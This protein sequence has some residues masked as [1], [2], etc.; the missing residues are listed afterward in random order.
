M[1]PLGICSPAFYLPCIWAML[2]T[3]AFYASRIWISF[4]LFW[5]KECS[6]ISMCRVLGFP[7]KPSAVQVLGTSEPLCHCDVTILESQIH[8]CGPT[9]PQEQTLARRCCP[10]IMV[11]QHWH[12]IPVQHSATTVTYHSH[13]MP[14]ENWH[15]TR[16][17]RSQSD[18]SPS[19]QLWT[20]G[21]PLP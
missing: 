7:P 2:C 16:K 1:H 20:F 18:T 13:G 19:C 21:S 17:R 3:W 14:L 9:P 6:W 11:L 15:P 5:W 10:H 12:Q 4:V 8:E